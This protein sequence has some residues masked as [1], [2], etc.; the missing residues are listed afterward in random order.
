MNL[1]FSLFELQICQIMNRYK[2]FNKLKKTAEV[3]VGITKF[4]FEIIKIATHKKSTINLKKIS[5]SAKTPAG[6]TIILPSKAA[7]VE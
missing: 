2:L 1:F 6:K 4:L 3:I 5:D 7:N